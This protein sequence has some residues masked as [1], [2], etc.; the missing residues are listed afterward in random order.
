[1]MSKSTEQKFYEKLEKCSKQLILHDG[2][3]LLNSLLK[4]RD[5]VFALAMIPYLSLF[6]NSAQDFFDVRIDNDSITEKE[7][8]RAHV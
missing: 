6:C 5:G 2:L 8:G 3:I 4:N 1:M 7:I